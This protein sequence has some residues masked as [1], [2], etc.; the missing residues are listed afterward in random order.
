MH[1][2]SLKTLPHTMGQRRK[3]E[4]GPKGHS[5]HSLL[6]IKY[7][8]VLRSLWMEWPSV[9]NGLGGMLSVFSVFGVRLRWITGWNGPRRV[10]LH[11]NV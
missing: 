10:A 3:R 1:T 8:K 2:T 11:K 5:T 6:P 7:Y 4:E 9:S